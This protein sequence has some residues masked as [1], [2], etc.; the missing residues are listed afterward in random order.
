MTNS[1]KDMIRI[2]NSDPKLWAQ[3]LNENKTNIIELIDIFQ[4]EIK[5]VKEVFNK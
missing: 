4:S 5:S 2:A 3:I 1:L